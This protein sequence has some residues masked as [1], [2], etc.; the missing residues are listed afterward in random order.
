MSGV[1]YVIRQGYR[2]LVATILTATHCPPCDIVIDW[3]PG[4][5]SQS[6]LARKIGHLA[7]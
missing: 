7:H 5:P 4:Q 3:G 1:N 6:R 2:L